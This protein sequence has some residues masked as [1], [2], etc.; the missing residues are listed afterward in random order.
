MTTESYQNT[1]SADTGDS[2]SK[3]D[4]VVIDNGN[5]NKRTFLITAGSLLAL[6]LLVVAGQNVGQDLSPAAT[7]I[8][9]GASALSDYQVDTANSALTYNIFGM[10]AVS[11]NEEG[12]VNPNGYSMAVTAMARAARSAV[13]A[14]ACVK[15][16]VISSAMLAIDTSTVATVAFATSPSAGPLSTLTALPTPAGTMTA[17]V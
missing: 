13:E 8:T 2:T 15:N 6:L 7:E 11:K 5:V 12:C 17:S 10:G 14:A 9:R 16:I 4:E 3:N 1:K